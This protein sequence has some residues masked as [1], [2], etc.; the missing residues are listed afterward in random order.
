MVMSRD[1]N[2]GQSRSIKI[3][4]SSFERMEG[5]KYLKKLLTNQNYIQEEIKSRLKSGIAYYHSVQNLLPSS[6]LSKNLKI[7]IYRVI[8]LPAV[9]YGCENL[10]LTMREKRRL[11]ALENRV[12]GI[13]FGSKRDEVTG[14]ERSK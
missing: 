2:A 8:I 12:L 11:W 3:D 6:L 9:L 13:I 5:F 10:L 7:K 4:S 14:M 1:Q